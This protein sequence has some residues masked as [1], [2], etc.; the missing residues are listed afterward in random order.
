MSGPLTPGNFTYAPEATSAARNA[1]FYVLDANGFAAG[2]IM[3]FQGAV[4]PAGWAIC[5]GSGG[6]PDLRN[7]FVI[8]VGTNAL[9]ATGGAASTLLTVDMLPD[10]VHS[11]IPDQADTGSVAGIGGPYVFQNYSVNSGGI[12]NGWVGGVPV[13]T[14]P[15]FYALAYIIK[16]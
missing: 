10:H 16:L 4:A 12:T 1:D 13:P 7:R 2:M 5:N 8:G 14:V 6:T 11:G 3:M 9:N 15:P